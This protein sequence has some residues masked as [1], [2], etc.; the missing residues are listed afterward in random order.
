[1]QNAYLL[2]ELENSTTAKFIKVGANRPFVANSLAA[3]HSYRTRL[4]NLCNRQ[5]VIVIIEV[6]PLGH[7][8]VLV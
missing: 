6:D 3:A 7:C 4:L 2:A 1:M 5:M 8:R